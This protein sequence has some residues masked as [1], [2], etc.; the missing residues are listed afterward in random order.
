MKKKIKIFTHLHQSTKRDYIDRM[1]SE[2]ILSMKKAKKFEYE[3]FGYNGNDVQSLIF[4]KK[5]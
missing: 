5:F 3:C 1:M 2:K 4:D